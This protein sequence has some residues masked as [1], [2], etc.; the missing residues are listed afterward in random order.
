MMKSTAARQ[1]DLPS[2][3]DAAGVITFQDVN[4]RLKSDTADSIWIVK[5]GAWS[6][7]NNCLLF[8]GDAD[9]LGHG[10]SATVCRMGH[11]N[12]TEADDSAKNAT[13]RQFIMD[14]FPNRGSCF[15][16]Q[17]VGTSQQWRRKYR[18]RAKEVGVLVLAYHQNQ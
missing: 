8:N 4:T 9:S 17:K 2:K 10:S 13:T 7:A 5:G 15:A 18:K 11:N 12:T 16:Y 3:R 6:I 1:Q 14:K